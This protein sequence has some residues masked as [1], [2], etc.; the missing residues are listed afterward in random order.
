MACIAIFERCTPTGQV[1]IG[2]VDADTGITS[3]YTVSGTTAVPWSGDVSTLGLC[4]GCDGGTGGSTPNTA[5]NTTFINGVL[6]T[7]VSDANGTITDSVAIPQCC[8][9]GMSLVLNGSTLTA[10]TTDANGTI[11]SNAVTLPT[12]GTGGATSSFSCVTNLDGS[13]VLTHNP[14][15][16]ST[17]TSCTIPSTII[18]TGVVLNLV[19]DQLTASVTDEAGTVTSQ[20]ITLPSGGGGGATSSLTS[21]TNA[22]GSVTYNHNDGLGNIVP[23]TVPPPPCGTA[24]IAGTTTGT[25]TGAFIDGCDVL[26]LDATG[27]PEILNPADG[28]QPGWR[29]RFTDGLTGLTES[30]IVEIAADGTNEWHQTS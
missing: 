13:I 6:S 10:T 29:Q 24:N 26:P 9:T 17:P 18:N 8:N 4:C 30:W 12:G 2:Q 28:F 19:G 14:G 25:V 15:D 7:S 3:Y 20:P 1:V 22:D 27:D 21:V 11:T 5:V 16:G 23:I